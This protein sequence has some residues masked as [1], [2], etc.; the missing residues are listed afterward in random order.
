MQPRPIPA[1]ATQYPRPLASSVKLQTPYPL[2][3]SIPASAELSWPP[4]AELD[5]NQAQRSNV[6]NAQDR[7]IFGSSTQ[8]PAHP[9]PLLEGL[10]P[11]KPDFNTPN[12]QSVPNQE[13]TEPAAVD[14]G[15]GCFSCPKRFITINAMIMH[16][17]AG[18]CKPGVNHAFFNSLCLEGQP[19]SH[20]THCSFEC[21]GCDELFHTFGTLIQHVERDA[22][23]ATLA[24]G[25][26]LA[27]FLEYVKIRIATM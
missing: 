25:S 18:D 3:D 26:P 5:L 24:N 19:N 17:E 10:I 9:K 7:R 22:C 13:A 23:K 2:L 20:T 1:Q 27:V 12:I 14:R 4:L 16:L 6:P 21:P 11:L 8:Q 15:V